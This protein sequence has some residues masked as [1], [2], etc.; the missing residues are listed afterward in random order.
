MVASA[1]PLRVLLAVVACGLL[2]ACTQTVEPDHPGPGATDSG[3]DDAGSRV[4]SLVYGS[5]SVDVALSALPTQDYKG[6]AV[7]P[8]TAV[9]AAG[10]LKDPSALEFD[11]EGD[12][13]FRPSTK[14]KCA[15]H[16]TAAQ[17]PKGYVLPDTRTLVW[18]DALG[19]PGC[20]SVHAIVKII[21]L[22]VPGDAG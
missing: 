17:L 6:A 1:H 21:G 10:G 19:L 13:G 18:D 2:P 3:L 12:D 7:V 20:Y 16:I 9:W 5:S 11:F 15:A 22:D 8:L 14:S 4:V